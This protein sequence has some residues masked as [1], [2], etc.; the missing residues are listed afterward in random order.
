MLHHQRGD[1]EQA[2]RCYVEALHRDPSLAETLWNLGILLDQGNH[3]AEAAVCYEQLTQLAPDWEDPW[4]RLATGHLASE[5]YQPAHDAFEACLQLRSDWLDAAAGL[6]LAKAKLGQEATAVQLLERVRE[7]DPTPLVLY[8]L[9]VLHQ[10]Q[11]REE[12]AGQYYREAIEMNPDFPEALL[13]L[14]HVMKN[15]GNPEEA[16]VLWRRAV[17]LRPAYAADYFA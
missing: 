12:T 2:R 5:R 16:Q 4:F 15:A 11:G 13:N 6:A 10:T 3:Q 17:R 1:L 7:I 9:A 8:N 14:G